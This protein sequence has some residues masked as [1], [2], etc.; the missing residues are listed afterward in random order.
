MEEV[1]PNAAGGTFSYVM[2]DALTVQ[3]MRLPGE[4][5]P[6]HA[7]RVFT[8]FKKL[9]KKIGGHEDTH[10]DGG[11]CGCGAEDKLDPAEGASILGYL[12]RRADD[13]RNVLNTYGISVS[14]A[15]HQ[16]IEQ[17]SQELHDEGYAAT[18]VEIRDVTREVG[19]E[20]SVKTLPG[21]HREVFLVLITNPRKKLNRARVA[22]AYDGRLQAFALNIPALAYG[23]SLL[24]VDQAE[25]DARFVGS[26]YYNVATAAVLASTGLG[27]I[28]KE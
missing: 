3:S 21:N 2:G 4:N 26:M 24:A 27:V 28:V 13:V 5:A 6:L 15:Q 25:A 12:S 17:R 11:N 23:A 19:G 14:D 8:D 10:Q 1:G 18:G 16:L 22:E 20:A 9:G 7:Q